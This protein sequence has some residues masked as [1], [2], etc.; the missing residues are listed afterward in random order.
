MSAV[1]TYNRFHLGDCL[2]SLHLLRA[3]AKQS[4]GRAFIFFTN[5]CNIPQLKEVVQDLPNILLEPFE[6][7]LWR[8]HERD[9]VDMWK[10]AEG[11]WEASRYRWEWSSFVL[12]HHAWTARRMGL[13]SP[14]ACREHLL[15]DYPALEIHGEGI[16]VQLERGDWKYTHGF[17]IG[18][19]APS[20]G[21]YSE[22][23]DHSQKPLERLIAQLSETHSILRT[24]ALQ[25][26]PSTVTYVGRIS[27]LC[28]HHIMVSNGPFWPTLNTTNHHNHEGRRRIVLLDNGENLNMPF[29]EQV[30][31]VEAVWDIARKERWV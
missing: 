24:S 12:E 8:D 6:S 11:F 13:H 9:A 21:Q 7:E 15:F 31:N 10:N 30:P 23:A 20:S 19:S 4:V 22:W 14:F 29:I 1:V 17:L 28:R 3:L 27:R 16:R 18:D 5:A 26:N 25:K 2:I